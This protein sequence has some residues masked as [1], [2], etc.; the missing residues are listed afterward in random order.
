MWMENNKKNKRQQE[1]KSLILV[2]SGQDA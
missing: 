1:P 2:N